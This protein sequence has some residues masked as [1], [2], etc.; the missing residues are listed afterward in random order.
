MIG[1]RL[2]KTVQRVEGMRSVWRRHDPFVVWLMQRFVEPRVVQATVD[3]VDEEI[4]EEDED[5]ELEEVVQIEGC[6]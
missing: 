3:Q 2:G 4:R 5:G 6:L 1:D